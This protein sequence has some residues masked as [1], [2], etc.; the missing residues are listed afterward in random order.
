MRVQ[1]SGP[2]REHMSSLTHPDN[3]TDNHPVKSSF[4]FYPHKKGDKKCFSLNEG[5][6]VECF[7][8]S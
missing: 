6:G 8:L 3:V 1:L 5:R 7:T 2:D 4:S